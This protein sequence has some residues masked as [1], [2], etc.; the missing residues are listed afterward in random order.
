MNLNVRSKLKF[1]NSMHII[2]S[3]TFQQTKMKDQNPHGRF[4]K[5]AITCDDVQWSDDLK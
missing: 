4:R 2:Q 5:R 3:T 1:D